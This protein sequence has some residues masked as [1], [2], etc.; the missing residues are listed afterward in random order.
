[1]DVNEL[2]PNRFRRVRRRPT[3]GVAINTKINGKSSIGFRQPVPLRDRTQSFTLY[4]VAAYE[5]CQLTTGKR[6]R[7][8]AV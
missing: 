8:S 5:K 4:F 7:P 6:Q 3:Q 1:M 2:R